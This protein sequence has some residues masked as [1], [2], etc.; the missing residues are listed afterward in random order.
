MGDFTT[1]RLVS[2]LE[3]PHAWWRETAHRLLDERH[4]KSAEAPLRRL[5]RHSSRPQSRLHALWSLAGLNVLSDRDLL[6]GLTDA[7]PAV[8]ENALRLAEPRPNH[9]EGI[10]SRCLELVADPNPRVRFQMAFTLGELNDPRAVK[11]LAMIARRD[12]A[13]DFIRT[14]ILSSSYPCA[15]ALMAELVR[16]ARFVQTESGTVLLEELAR[17]VGGR[18][19]REEIKSA[20]EEIL[21]QNGSEVGQIGVIGLSEGLR[22]CGAQLSSFVN[23]LDSR[24]AH[25]FHALMEDALQVIRNK[26]ASANSIEKALRLLEN[27]S[28]DPAAAPIL[29]LLDRFP[30]APIQIAAI[31]ALSK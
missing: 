28:P 13:D 7:F 21:G 30:P 24:A 8:R 23:S 17:V 15:A 19:R 18:N 5:L 2:C 6:T 16:D 22:N 25:R 12:A 4:D 31:R 11:G 10:R 27:A 29:A 26:D 14:A 3:S 9:S 1:E 20:L